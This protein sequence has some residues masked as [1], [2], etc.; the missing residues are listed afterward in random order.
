MK[1]IF[2]D[3]NR[4]MAAAVVAALML[5]AP[6]M[7]MAA[8]TETSQTETEVETVSIGEK[9][10][11]TDYEVTLVNETGD[12][13]KE[14]ALRV[15]YGEFS[16]NM[17]AE[18]TVLADK[19][20]GT[21]WCTPGEIVNYVPPVYDLQLTFADDSTAVLH[22]LPFGDTEEITIV[23]DDEKDIVYTRFFSISMNSDTDSQYRE[24]SIAE[25]GEDTLIADYNAKLTAVNYSEPAGDSS[26][27]GT[28]SSGGG[29]SS[30][31]K[32][33]EDGQLF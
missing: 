16:D 6:C 25:S 22:T 30:K 8:E 29:S 13:I 33:V 5:N 18:D 31:K 3:R 12:D 28:P 11:D 17:L 27:S 14:I 32:C 2:K 21:L 10:A 26:Y 23:K 9:T 4:M 1:S 7:I 19:G 24:N 15:S 20:Q